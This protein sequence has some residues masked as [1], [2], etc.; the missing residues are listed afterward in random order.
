MIVDS[1]ALVAI[2]RREE[3]AERYARA[4]AASAR[5]RLSAATYLEVA[6]V[7]DGHR[8]PVLSRTLDALLQTAAIEIVDLTARQAEIARQAH[9]DFGRGSG[10][11]AKLNYGDCFSYALAIETGEPLL[12]KGDDF[13]HTDVRSAVPR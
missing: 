11:P 5:T 9:R 10:H 8:E 4:L 2:L 12:Y 1:S 7:I 3:D 6:I 13:V